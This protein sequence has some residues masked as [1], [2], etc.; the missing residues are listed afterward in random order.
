[1]NVY[2]FHYRFKRGP[3]RWL[4]LESLPEKMWVV[5]LEPFW[6]IK[7]NADVVY[8]TSTYTSTYTHLAISDQLKSYHF[9]LEIIYIYISI[10]FPVLDNNSHA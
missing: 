3:N 2:R 6:I 9:G 5:M 4:V 10:M 8:E 1:M 7:T